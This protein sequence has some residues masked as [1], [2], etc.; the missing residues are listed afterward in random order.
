MKSACREYCSIMRLP[1]KPSQTPETTAVFFSV[2]PS[3]IVVAST[4]LRRRV[5]AH[6][7]E[8]LHDVRRAEE[9]RADHVLRA[10]A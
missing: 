6:D 5:A 3:F 9:V 4:S 10:A 7:L 8:Q 2:L 1:M